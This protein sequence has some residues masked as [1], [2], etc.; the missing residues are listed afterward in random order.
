MSRGPAA[1]RG[2]LPTA[3]WLTLVWMALWD[4]FS[5][6]NLLNGAL[7]A[8]ALLAVF[9]AQ[10]PRHELSLRPLAALRFLAY[11]GWELVKANA[12]VAWQVVRPGVRLTEGVVA[13]PVRGPSE[14]IVT[15][16]A[17]AITLTPGTLTLE[18]DRDDAGTVLYVHVLQ[19]TD[20]EAIR[21]DVRELEDR[22]IAAFGGRAGS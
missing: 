6:A 11:F 1:L 16:V 18:V 8:V 21:R 5:F 19:L 14:A 4:D 7:V 9:P 20:A 13:V 17:N 10:G 22:A 2:A 12:V 15:L 3:S